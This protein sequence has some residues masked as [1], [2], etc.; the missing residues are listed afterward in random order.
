MKLNKT[1]KVGLYDFNRVTHGICSYIFMPI[2]A[3]KTMLCYSYIYI[4]I[5]MT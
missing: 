2:H 4:Y 3:V 1:K 5:Y